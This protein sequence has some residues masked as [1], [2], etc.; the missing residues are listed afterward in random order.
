MTNSD[1]KK[2]TIINGVIVAVAMV[3]F[4]F[5]LAV[6]FGIACRAATIH[7]YGT[8]EAIV[9]AIGTVFSL[10]FPFF[11]GWTF[12]SLIE[13]IDCDPRPE[14]RVGRDVLEALKSHRR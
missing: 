10:V 2:W 6:L 8:L 3:G 5:S 9:S 4:Y 1:R 14:S 13:P 7:G 12:C 11:C